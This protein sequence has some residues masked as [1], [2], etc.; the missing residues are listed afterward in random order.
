M[1][2]KIVVSNTSPT[3]QTALSAETHLA[4]G[5]FYYKN[6]KWTKRSLWHTE[7]EIQDQ[8]FPSRTDLYIM[9]AWIRNNGSR[10]YLLLYKVCNFNCWKSK[11][12]TWGLEETIKTEGCELL[13]DMFQFAGITRCNR[14]QNKR[15]ILKLNLNK[16]KIY[17]HMFKGS[18]GEG[19]AV[20]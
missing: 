16:Y 13:L 7:Q 14:I 4:W 10:W 6:R 3:L 2:K 18:E 17:A 15:C 19:Y 9:Q 8:Y 20:N 5:Q 1:I 11:G 12:I